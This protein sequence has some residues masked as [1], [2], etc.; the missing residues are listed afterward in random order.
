MRHS[1]RE[2]DVT[3]CKPTRRQPPRTSK[4]GRTL[5]GSHGLSTA[6]ARG[7]AVL[8]AII[9]LTLT[10]RGAG[11]TVGRQVGDVAGPPNCDGSCDFFDAAG[12]PDC[13]GKRHTVIRRGA[14]AKGRT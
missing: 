9:I 11:A 8:Y 2:G 10:V 13:L 12:S 3:A 7:I 4:L 1:S 6:A 14:N 5:R